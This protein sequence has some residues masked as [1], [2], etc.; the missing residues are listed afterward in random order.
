M[1]NDLSKKLKSL[2]IKSGMTQ[3]ELARRVKVSPSCIGMYEQGRREPKSHVLSK[4]CRELD[5]TG[6]YILDLNKTN[7]KSKEFHNI[8]QEFTEFLENEN[9]I[10]INGQPLDREDIRRITNALKVATAVVL[11]DKK[12]NSK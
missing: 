8:I 3:A 5:A 2:R 1:A 9:N 12:D 7:F 4:M 11:E 6:D 10:L